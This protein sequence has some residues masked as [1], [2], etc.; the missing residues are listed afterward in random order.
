MCLELGLD[1]LVLHERGLQHFDC[2]LAVGVGRPQAA[3]A[4]FRWQ[5]SGQGQELMRERA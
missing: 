2:L 3:A 4:F 1:Q 5:D